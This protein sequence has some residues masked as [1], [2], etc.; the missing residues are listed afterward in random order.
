[1]KRILIYS[2]QK[3]K[4]WFIKTC[5]VDICV[6][7]VLATS[8]KDD[9]KDFLKYTEVVINGQTELSFAANTWELLKYVFSQSVQKQ[10]LWAFKQPKNELKS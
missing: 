3:C 2:I 1:M 10:G 4:F 7:N 8:T 5:I 9:W 6:Y